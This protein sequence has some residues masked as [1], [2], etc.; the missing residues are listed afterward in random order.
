MAYLMVKK[1]YKLGCQYIVSDCEPA[2]NSL[3]LNESVTR[4]DQELTESEDQTE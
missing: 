3:G 1:L 2:K 4:L